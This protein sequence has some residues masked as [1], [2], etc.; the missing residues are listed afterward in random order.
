MGFVVMASAWAVEIRQPVGEPVFS[1]A[2]PLPLPPETA[3]AAGAVSPVWQPVLMRL[4]T[5]G[6]SGA[7]VDAMFAALGETA[8]QEPMG[9]K[10]RELYTK[11]FLRTPPD[12]NAP[13]KARL[14]LYKGVVTPENAQVC[15]AFLAQNGAY[16]TRAQQLYGVPP[17]IAV[18]LLFVETRLGTSM[19]K[20]RALYT[21]ASMAQSTSP[22]SINEWLPRLPGYEGH[23]DWMQELMPKRADWA[24]KE[25]R[26]L[27]VHLRTQG[28][29]ASTVPGSIYGAVGMCQFMPS[30]LVPY[31]AD[32]DDDGVVDLF[33][34]PDA[35]AS[36]SNYLA[37]H[38]WKPDISRAAQHAV[39]KSYNRVDIYANTIM[40]LADLIAGRPL[41]LPTD[42][43][44][45]KQKA[46]VRP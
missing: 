13:P 27:V 36:L 28:I 29:E 18:A 30:N 33:T 8:S 37:R 15:K 9:R 1:D 7:D 10:I 5:D 19:G 20:E 40:A 26:A 2:A 45:K 4:A 14:R 38:G 23:L 12:P 41:P 22:D 17:E 16:F 6:I 21:L 39:L 42:E 11:A 44:I 43:P 35:V 46:R 25:L 3:P 34:V 31:G 32:G 24:Y